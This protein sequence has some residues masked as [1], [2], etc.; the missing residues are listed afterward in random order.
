M[1]AAA[2][3]R[4]GAPRPPPANSSHPGPRTYPDEH[5]EDSARHR[6][7]EAD[8]APR[9]EVAGL[10]AATIGRL[11]MGQISEIP[12]EALQ[13][14]GTE[15]DYLESIDG[16]TAALLIATYPHASAGSWLAWTGPRSRL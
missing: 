15:N 7:L 16:K 3:R 13:P 11:C 2:A 14:D 6:T 8:R 5:R 12:E 4:P 9:T 1:T 10:L